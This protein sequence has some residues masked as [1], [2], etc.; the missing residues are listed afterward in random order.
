MNPY[1]AATS[2]Q[3]NV[4]INL[5]LGYSEIGYRLSRVTKSVFTGMQERLRHM[6]VNAR[7]KAGLTQVELSIRLS[8]PRRSCPR[9]NAVSDALMSLSSW[10]SLRQLVLNQLRS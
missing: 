7:K 6:L 5:F 2:N 4:R 10:R 9:P 1:R 3:Q 8:R